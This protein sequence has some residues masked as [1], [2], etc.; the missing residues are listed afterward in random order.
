MAK[1]DTKRKIQ[2]LFNLQYRLCVLKVIV[3]RIN[4][5]GI[6]FCDF[7]KNLCSAQCWQNQ[8]QRQKVQIK[9][10]NTEYSVS[11][12]RYTFNLRFCEHK[13]TIQDLD[14]MVTP[15]RKPNLINNV[16]RSYRDFG[17]AHTNRTSEQ[18]VKNKLV[19]LSYGKRQEYTSLLQN[20]LVKLRDGARYHVYYRIKFICSTRF[21]IRN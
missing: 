2:V 16:S 6:N 7:G 15:E 12:V 1:S 10:A 17:L 14:S 8:V 19:K 5:C 3:C 18:I 11:L 21:F 20:K 13:F 9:K 4:Y